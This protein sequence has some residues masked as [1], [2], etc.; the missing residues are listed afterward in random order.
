MLRARRGDAAAFEEIVV[1]HQ[2]QVY[3]TA[4]R[5]LRRHELAD[6]VVQEAF[7]R[8]YRSLGSFDVSRPF[9]PWIRRIARN[10]ALNHVRAGAF[11]EQPLP[12]TVDPPMAPPQDDPLRQALEREAGDVLERALQSLPVEQQAVFA[13]RVFEDLSYREIAQSLAIQPGTVMSRLA[14]ARERLREALGGYLG[15]AAAR[16]K[17]A[18][19]A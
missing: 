6:E 18:G 16:G 5:V 2:R 9:G 17:E 3:A 7:L 15:S 12:E 1:R 11:R 4:R 10:L 19:P 8:A 14:R 13:L